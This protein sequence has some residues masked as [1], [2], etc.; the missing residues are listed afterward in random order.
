MKLDV[1]T[2]VWRGSVFGPFWHHFCCFFLWERTEI[3]HLTNNWVFLPHLFFNDI[4][5]LQEHQNTINHVIWCSGWSAVDIWLWKVGFTPQP[6]RH[7]L[8]DINLSSLGAIKSLQAGLPSN[9]KLERLTSGGPCPGIMPKPYPFRASGNPLWD[10]SPGKQNKKGNTTARKSKTPAR[11]HC[12]PKMGSSDTRECGL[13]ARLQAKLPP[14]LECRFTWRALWCPPQLPLVPFNWFSM[15]HPNYNDHAMH[16]SHRHAVYSAILSK[17]TATCMFL[18]SQVGRNPWSLTFTQISWQPILTCVI[19][20]VRCQLM[21][22]PMLPLNPGQAKRFL[23][24]RLP[25]ISIS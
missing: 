11:K 12:P 2:Q 14:L 19:T 25:G 9:A 10:F 17:A 15:C 6:I 20:L 23:Y 3:R 7:G 18:P 1:E 13:S 8:P 24:P 16:L 21:R 5:L 4:C 22:S